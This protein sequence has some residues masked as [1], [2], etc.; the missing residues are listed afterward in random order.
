MI[1]MAKGNV[2]AAVVL[3]AFAFYYSYESLQ[4][5]LWTDVGPG[6]GALPTLSGILLA[7]LA[8]ALL[9]RNARKSSSEEGEADFAHW[10]V[11]LTV[12]FGV[13]LFVL[14]AKTLGMLLTIL[15]FMVLYTLGVERI[16]WPVALPFSAATAG[17]FYLIFEVWLDVPL[18][19]GVFGI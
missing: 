5:P 17:M 11:A 10:R 19:I 7:V 12:L 2:Y 8:L 15:L 16:R 6:A 9:L 14:L 13:F 18:A 3:L 4:L 1:S